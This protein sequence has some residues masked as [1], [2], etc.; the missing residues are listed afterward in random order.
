MLTATHRAR[1][2]RACDRGCGHPIRPG[3]LIEYSATPPRRS[4]WFDNP[5][6]MRSVTHAGRCPIPGLTAKQWNARH[7]AGTTVYAWPGAL[8]DTP[9]L[10]RTRSAAWEL[11]SGHPVVSVEGHDEAIALIHLLPL[12]NPYG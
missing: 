4:F 9:V 12:E 10:R 1:K 2:S 6:W 11:E 3:D 7:L 5:G 8:T